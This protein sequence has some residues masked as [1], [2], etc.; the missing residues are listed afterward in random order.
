MPSPSDTEFLKA[1]A[2]ALRRADADGTAAPG[3][4]H[5]LEN[6]LWGAEVIDFLL[7]HPSVKFTPENSSACSPNCRPR[8][9]SVASSLRVFPIKC[10]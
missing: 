7:D 9:Y 8:L 3:S 6:Y 5:D 10:T 2:N 1:I 4:Q